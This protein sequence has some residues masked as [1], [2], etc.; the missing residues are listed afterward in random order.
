MVFYNAK[1]TTSSPLN[2]VI[3]LLARKTKEKSNLLSVYFLIFRIP[4]LL[5]HPTVHCANII[6][7]NYLFTQLI[8]L[9]CLLP[10]YMHD[11]VSH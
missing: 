9:P 3:S 2:I 11:A 1:A 10:D 5:I 8:P 6:K 4:M 7:P